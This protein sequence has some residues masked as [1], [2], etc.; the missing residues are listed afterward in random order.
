MERAGI[1]PATSGL[2]ILSGTVSRGNLFDVRRLCDWDQR[3]RREAPTM[4][5]LI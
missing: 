5:G 2:Q 1:E 3:M 4:V